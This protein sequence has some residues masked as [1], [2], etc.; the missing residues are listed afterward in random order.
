[1]VILSVHGTS[2]P[3]AP[4]DR[5]A[6]S[7]VRPGPELPRLLRVL[8]IEDDFGD[9]D[10]VARALRKI[11]AFEAMPT[12]AKTLEAARK[13]MSEHAYDVLLVDY[14]LG[15]ECGSRLL[16]EIG[17]R[18]SRAVPILLTG[19]ADPRVHDLALSAGAICCINKRDLSPTLLEMTMRSA[20]Y[21]H[22]LEWEVMIL[23]KALSA[24]E[25][26]NARSILT[27]IHERMPWLTARPRPGTSAA[28]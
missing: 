16:D 17:G 24:G 18:G 6:T 3:D 19:E 21:T 22:R 9:Y 8:V 28:L 10:A 26:D 25:L 7:T 2:G 15:V 1:M 27:L 12:R 23:V 4:M 13:L 5:D 20:L 11:G 14:N